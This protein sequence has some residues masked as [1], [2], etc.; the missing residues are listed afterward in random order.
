MIDYAHHHGW[1]TG[2]GGA[3]DL[4]GD[5]DQN[6]TFVAYHGAV[7]WVCMIYVYPTTIRVELCHPE[8]QSERVAIH[9]EPFEHSRRCKQPFQVVKGF[10]GLTG[11][12]RDP[13]A[14]APFGSTG[15]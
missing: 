7:R 1:F 10:P 12:V 13:N 2:P 6:T 14:I 15:L 8:S 9:D 3:H 4:N 5:S 11:V